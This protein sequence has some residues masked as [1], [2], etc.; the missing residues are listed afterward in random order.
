MKVH[1]DRDPLPPLP[2]SGKSGLLRADETTK[3]VY[4]S[5]HMHLIT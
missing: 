4:V 2:M 3:K 1:L 5:S